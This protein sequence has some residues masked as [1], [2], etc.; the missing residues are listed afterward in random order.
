MCVEGI[1][2]EE[3]YYNCITRDEVSGL[4]FGFE[5]HKSVEFHVQTADVDCCLL[6][7]HLSYK[8]A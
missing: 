3:K 1:N 5:I 6:S 8:Q 7:S 4:I 2:I